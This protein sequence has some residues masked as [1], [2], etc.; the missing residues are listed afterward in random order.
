MS[1]IADTDLQEQGIEAQGIGQS[2]IPSSSGFDYPAI[3]RNQITQLNALL[4]VNALKP[5]D[6]LRAIETMVKLQERLE[7][8][9]NDTSASDDLIAWCRDVLKS[10]KGADLPFSPSPL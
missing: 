7:S 5:S 8:R 3:L 9:E 6:R 1:V 2:P 4:S 10:D